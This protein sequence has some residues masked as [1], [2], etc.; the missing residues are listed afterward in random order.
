MLDV[1]Q[2]GVTCVDSEGT[3]ML[4]RTSP[5]RITPWPGVLPI[6]LAYANPL[7]AMRGVRG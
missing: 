3:A 7:R 5:S 1:P 6:G 4:E 2:V